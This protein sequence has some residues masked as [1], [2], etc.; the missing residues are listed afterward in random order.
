MWKTTTTPK[1]RTKGKNFMFE[2]MNVL[3]M[4]R[5]ILLKLGSSSR[6]P[7]KKYF[8]IFFQP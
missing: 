5:G 7:K 6:R 1:K 4:G 3:F 8:A 2:E